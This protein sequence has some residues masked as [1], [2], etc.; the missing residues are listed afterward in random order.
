MFD[1][2]LYLQQLEQVLNIAGTLYP[3]VKEKEAYFPSKGAIW[4][5]HS[6]RAPQ[7]VHLRRCCAV[8]LWRTGPS[9]FSLPHS[10]CSLYIVTIK[11]CILGR[12]QIGVP[13]LWNVV[14]LRHLTTVST[15]SSSPCFS[16]CYQH[17][18][19]PK[20]YNIPGP[21]WQ[22]FYFKQPMQLEQMLWFAQGFWFHDKLVLVTVCLEV[23]ECVQ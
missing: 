20:F 18:S 22:W 8:H 4:Q 2:S 10:N 9:N 13:S 17:D 16:L 5:L 15:E 23:L 7:T 3:S 11:L 14:V 21:L 12:E 19:T 1:S 6:L